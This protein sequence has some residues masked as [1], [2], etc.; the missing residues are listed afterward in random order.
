M[1]TVEGVKND[2]L[3]AKEL[4]QRAVGKLNVLDEKIR[5]LRA[6]VSDGLAVTQE[7]IDELGALSQGVLD[8]LTQ[9]ESEVAE[10][11]SLTGEESPVVDPVVSPDEPAPSE[12]PKV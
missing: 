9:V 6:K 7:N 3:A 11:D 1:E 10:A 2:L 4:A 8:A 5:V 12:E